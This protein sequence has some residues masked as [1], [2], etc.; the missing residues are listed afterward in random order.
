MTQT[1]PLPP[2]T[3]PVR[4][5]LHLGKMCVALQ[6][7]TPAEMMECAERALADTKFVEFRLD[8]LPKPA[9]VLPALKEFLSARRDVTAIATCRRKDNGGSFTGTLSAELE[10]LL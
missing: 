6:A 9:A 7:R 8:S 5:R 3:P 1:A 4:P 10:L 2:A